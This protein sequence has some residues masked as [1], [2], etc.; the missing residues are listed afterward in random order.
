MKGA[1]QIISKS[2][3]F[4]ERAFIN[5]SWVEA[6]ETFPVYFPANGEVIAN[7]A[8]VDH[9][10]TETAI[11]SA[12]EAFKDWKKTSCKY[13][14]DMLR[15]LYDL[16]MENKDDLAEIMTAECGKPIRESKA[17]INYGASFLQWFSEEAKRVNGDVLPTT[18]PNI[19]RM[20]LKQPIGVAALITP[21]NFP[22]AMITRK[23][24][25]ALAAGCTVVMKP[26]EETPLTALALCKMAE[27][28]KFPPGVINALPCSRT[29]TTV[30]GELFCKSPHIQTISFT[31]STETGRWLL[32]YS[33]DTVKRVSLELGGNAPFIVFD[34]ANMDLV[35]KAAMIAKFRNT[36][37]TCIS[38]NRFLVQSNI[39][40]EFIANYKSTIENLIV[41]NP[42][43]EDTEFSCLINAKGLQKVEEHIQ[44]AVSK[45]ATIITGGEGHTLGGLYYRP[46]ILVDCKPDMQVMADETFGPVVSVLKFENEAEAVAIANSSKVGLAAYVCSQN[47]SQI[48]RVSENL[49]VGM[50]GV[51]EGLISTEMIPFG[52]VKQSGLGREGSS[53]GM[54]EYL[55]LKYVCLGGIQI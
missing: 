21:W 32:K 51:N 6:K 15:S 43:D 46:T 24:G 25:A 42:L 36:G 11:K 48:W 31:G 10:M 33:A 12:S 47:L 28:I 19:R 45:G 53:Y 52:G 7:V 17:E 49:E 2:R 54:D 13:R 27:E 14:S 35:L 55:E 26:S 29:H 38:A 9:E 41:G 40:D 5:G 20:V 37:Q 8:D 16:V 3:L 50:V 4:C 18:E 23:L 22:L 44:D 39:Y 34:S 30:I 1:K